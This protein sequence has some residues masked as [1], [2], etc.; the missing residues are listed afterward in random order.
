MLYVASNT[1]FS[2][3]LPRL[4]TGLLLSQG[5][6]FAFVAFGL[7]KSFKLI[8]PA[9]TKIFMT[10]VALSMATTPFLASLASS[11]AKKLEQN[12][13]FSHYLGQD[14]EAK[15][16][17]GGDFVVVVGYGVVG[18]MVCDLLDRKFQRYIGVESD[19]K[20]AI[21]ARNKGLPVFYGD[22]TRSEVC[23]A[24]NVGS[25]KSVI[26]TINDLREINRAVITLRRQFPEMQIF[27]R[28]IDADHQR[29]LQN[30][31]GVKAMVSP[32]DTFWGGSVVTCDQRCA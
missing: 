9:T 12:M 16:I 27:A 6:E 20:K 7:A 14:K 18:K 29:R 10:T 4:Q 31:L 11:V 32:G 15:E 22:V 3:S 21:L 26:L 23:E 17:E 25:A 19:P 8:D 24:F 2:R 13:G 30:T 1:R 5:G 28:A